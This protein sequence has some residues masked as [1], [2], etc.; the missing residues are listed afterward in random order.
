[1][2]I[3]N[4][5][6]DQRKLFWVLHVGGWLAWGLIAKYG[7]NR[8]FSEETLPHYFLYVMVISVIGMV[9]TLGLRAVYRYLWSR[10]PWIQALG[11][12]S[13]CAAGGFLWLKSRT[14][15]F[16]GWIEH[17]EEKEAWAEKM[18]DAAEVYEKISVILID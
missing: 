18:G 15:I 9:I 3:K 16:Y 12:I 1:M 7:Y 14:Y 13:A 11:F 4:L 2:I 8:V 17:G 6:K 5:V 10:R